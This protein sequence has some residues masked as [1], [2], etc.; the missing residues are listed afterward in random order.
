MFTCPICK[1]E[2]ENKDLI[3]KHI[4][5][6][7]YNFK[8]KLKCVH[9]DCVGRYG[10]LSAFMHHVRKYHYMDID[11]LPYGHRATAD[12]VDDGCHDYEP[13]PPNLEADLLGDI[14]N[15]EAGA[16]QNDEQMS[17]LKIVDD[18]LLKLLGKG[19]I[20][21]SFIEEI[22]RTFAQ[23]VEGMVENVYQIF[24]DPLL[25][26]S[27]LMSKIKS[28]L[29]KA[30]QVLNGARSKYLIKKKVSSNPSF[31][32]ATRIVFGRRWDSVVRNG[33][34]ENVEIEETGFI[35]PPSQTIKCLLTNT[36]CGSVLLN[37]NENRI[38]GRYC[39]SADGK[40]CTDH[41][42]FS[43]EDRKSLRLQLFY[44][45]MGT[46][47]CLRGHATLYNLAL[48]YFSIENMP[49]K[50]NSSYANVHLLAMC[51]TEDIK[52]YGF[53]PI[54]NPIMDDIVLTETKGLEIEVRGLG[55]VQIYA[56]LSTFCADALATN[57]IFGLVE[58]FSH[59]FYCPIGYVTR[60]SAL[61]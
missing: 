59:D 2:I 61:I 3:R 56:G 19:T 31:V 29:E 57:K 16:D 1:L 13:N 21:H 32:P 4:F 27:D 55:Q 8:D 38:D 52:R 48:F 40:K 39:T 41:P 43:R 36:D 15:E 22:L 28:K 33:I 37:G 11:Y 24:D 50:L 42:L 10:S 9:N 47:N 14:P 49:A 6:H 18:L 54:L 17:Y 58:S 60:A 23:F 7:K 20:A 26:S 34:A 25:N 46:T 12:S 45:D 53:G 35:I 5:E 30:K 51:L 44:D